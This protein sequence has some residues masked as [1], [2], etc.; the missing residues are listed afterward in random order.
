MVVQSLYAADVNMGRPLSEA[1][2]FLD[3]RLQRRKALVEFAYNLLVGV[4]NHRIAIDQALSKTATNWS[5]RRMAIIDRNILR[6]G[7]YEILHG[8]T[9]GS[10]AINE[11]IELAKRYGERHSASFVNGVLDRLLKQRT[12][13]A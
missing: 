8:D 1:Q 5:L 11:A 6:L 4:T 3:R 13:V 9:P 2:E 10:V 7:A 12:P